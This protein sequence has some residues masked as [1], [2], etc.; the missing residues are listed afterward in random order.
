MRAL[1]QKH[2]YFKFYSTVNIVKVIIDILLSLIIY[3]GMGVR[4]FIFG[5]LIS[6]V[7]L[8]V[9]YTLYLL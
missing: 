8:V 7:L 6:L 4:G 2:S 1:I 3:G 5:S 9:L